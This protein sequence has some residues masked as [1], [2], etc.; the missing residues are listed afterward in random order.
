MN[1][2]K[3]NGVWINIGK[4]ML[5][6]SPEV[7][8]APY[9][10]KTFTCSSNPR[11]ATVSL[12]GLGWHELYVNGKK[13]DDRVLAPAVTQYDK[14]VSYIDYDVTGL[15]KPGKNAVAVLLGNGWYNCHTAEVWSF[16]KAP[17]RDWPKLICDIFI[18]GQLAAKSDSSW[19][20]HDSPVTFDALRNGEHYDARLEI[21][22]F[23]DADFDDSAWQNA[24]QCPPPGGLLCE[25]DELPCRIMKE[26]QP[27]KETFIFAH[28]TVYDFGTNLTG[29]CE[30]QVRGSAGDRVILEHAEQVYPNGNICQE[31]NSACI[32]KDGFQMDIYTLK[33]EG[34][35]TFHPHFT[36]HGFRYARVQFDFPSG[37]K[38]Q[39]ASIK[40][41]F[42]HNDFPSAGSFQSSDETLNRLQ[43]ITRQTYLCNFTGIPTDCPHREKNGWTGDA[44][45]ACETGLWNFNSKSGYLHFL[46]ILA[47]AQRPNGQ[48][49][50]IAP[51]GGWGY[52]KANGPAWDSMLFEGVWQLYLFYGDAEPA[53]ELYG[54]MKR[55][56]SYCEMQANE[57]LVGFGLGDWCHPDMLRTAPAELTSSGFYYQDTLR[58][59]KFAGLFGKLDDARHY[60]ALAEAIRQSFNRKF[61]KGNGIYA[62]GCM[63]SLATPLY[64]GLAEQDH[65]LT[66]QR[67]AETVE[68]NGGRIDF[69]ILGAK[70]VPRVLAEYGYAETAFELITQPEFP[71]W[72]FWVKSGATT[73]WEHWNGMYSQNHIMFGDISAWMFRYPAGAAPAFDAPG[74]R[75]FTVKPC[76]IPQLNHVRMT[77]NTPYGELRIAWERTRGGIRGHIQI[78]DGCS[79]ELHLPGQV[80]QNIREPFQFS[81]AETSF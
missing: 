8:R 75:R 54:N 63:T 80:Q 9:L 14:R 1:M 27:V 19:K 25:E 17:W 64:F 34:L 12:C 37:N 40:A 62:D 70:F 71:G 67:L 74:F 46:R 69:G 44:Q 6:P 61:Y 50:G 36:Y 53:R 5:T 56:I 73:L 51:T 81:L 66:A 32:K 2:K 60:A 57:N 78:P 18:D 47:D 13:A 23:A 76:F 28:Q 35:E 52:N 11:K 21:P 33:G 38:P 41:Q 16:D 58:L 48:L 20:F 15:L 30:I 24:V 39:I 45:L 43:Q 65:A 79:A 68:A 59:A 7:G 77:H 31:L 26:Y 10:R 29:W 49:P 3:W 55:Y 22:G 72:G 4:T 42:I